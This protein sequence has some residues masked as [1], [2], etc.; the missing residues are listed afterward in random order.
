MTIL[1]HSRAAVS[2]SIRLVAT[3]YPA[4]V[5]T[6]DLQS[7]LS[8]LVTLNQWLASRLSRAVTSRLFTTRKSQILTEQRL[9]R[10]TL[11]LFAPESK[12][13]IISPS[14]G[15]SSALRK[16]SDGQMRG[17]SPPGKKKNP[18]HDI[19]M[20]EEEEKLNAAVSRLSA[21][22]AMFRRPLDHFPS[23]DF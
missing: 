23:S 4:C 8:F 2:P 20:T 19:H 17:I 21:P 15:C 16:E 5:M 1:Q 9:R 22:A 11:G 12:C 13:N 7:Q 6:P 10:Q 3:I 18:P 14:A